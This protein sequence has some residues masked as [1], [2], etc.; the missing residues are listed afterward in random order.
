MTECGCSKRPGSSVL[1]WWPRVVDGKEGCRERTQAEE[2]EASGVVRSKAAVHRV[3][4]MVESNTPRIPIRN[5]L[6]SVHRTDTE[7]TALVSSLKSSL[8]G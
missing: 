3:R 2:S 1:H 5:G 4:E 6:T 8:T 7:R